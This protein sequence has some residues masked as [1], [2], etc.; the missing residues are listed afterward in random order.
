MI[1]DIKQ[2]SKLIHQRVSVT[3]NYEV[4]FTQNLF[5]LK[6]PTLAQVISA[7]EETK[8]KKVVA[9]VDAGILK[10]QPEL[11]KQLVA[12]TKFYGEVLAIAAEPM[13][14]SGGEAAKN[15]RTL[16][17]QIQQL[18]ETAGLCR[19][20]YVLA[21]GGGAVLDLVGYAAAT[22]HRGIRLI[23]VPTTVL[24]QNDS[25]V[26]VK[27]GIN[28]FGKKNFLGTFAPPYAVI[29]DSAFLTTLDDRD[30]RSGIAEAVKV[31]L[32][33]D[34]KFF[35]FI[36]SH[37]K[38]LGRRDMDA[39]QEVIYRCAQL[40]LEHIANS[41]DPFE[42]GSSRPLDFGHWAAHKL[43]HLTNYRLRHG[44]AVAIGIALD[45]TYSYLAGLLDCSE[46]QRILNTLSA[47][48]FTL[49]VPE[50]VEKLSQLEHPDCLF[51]G[52]TEF[53][54]HLGG[55]LTLTLLKSIGKAIEVHEVNL[56]LYRQAISL[57]REF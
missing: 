39:M 57:L 36:H 19:H 22:A 9:V 44:E 49:Y 33:K 18:I 6:N 51:R 54:E 3:F 17:E 10:Y 26:G 32:I 37:S 46:W 56:L 47:L 14:I 41:G 38:A 25:G 45:S 53:R 7:D 8:P 24:A 31:A 50:M 34:A 30:W 16:V 43:E 48:G 4:Y 28:A 1:V 55:E 35:D 23:R 40:H 15:D 29:N 2:K 21:I 13:I 27:N 42:M 20:S 11:L 52:L 12:Y 5:E